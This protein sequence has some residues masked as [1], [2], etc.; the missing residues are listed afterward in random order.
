MD[1]TSVQP[2]TRV[3]LVAT[4][5]VIISAFVAVMIGVRTVMAAPTEWLDCN[6]IYDNEHGTSTLAAGSYGQIKTV[7]TQFSPSCYWVGLKGYVR[8]DDTEYAM[9]GFDPPSD[10]WNPGYPS[11]ITYTWYDSGVQE[12]SAS[13]NVCRTS[14][15]DDCNPS[16]WEATFDN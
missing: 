3:M 16:G 7:N 15:Y 10:A 4:I 12:A 8:Y 1:D 13:H 2:R 6:T 5:A 9:W 14:G 11:N